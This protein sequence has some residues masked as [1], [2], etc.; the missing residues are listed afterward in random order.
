LCLI[1]TLAAKRTTYYGDV[2]GTTGYQATI[3]NFDG[4]TITESNSHQDY[5]RLVQDVTRMLR[6]LFWAAHPICS[7]EFEDVYHTEGGMMGMDK[8]GN[9]LILQDFDPSQY[10]PMLLSTEGL[11]RLVNYE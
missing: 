8:N 3:D 4:N 11:K 2:E 1:V 5:K 6:V 9:G 10:G 7:D